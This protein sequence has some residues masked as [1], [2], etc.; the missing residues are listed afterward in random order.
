[1]RRGNSLGGGTIQIHGYGLLLC[2]DKECVTIGLDTNPVT[3][4]MNR[5]I[6]GAETSGT[7]IAD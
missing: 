2:A 3:V 6:P 5:Q 7:R 4:D 1:M